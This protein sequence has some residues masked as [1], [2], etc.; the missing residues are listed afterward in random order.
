[1]QYALYHLVVAGCYLQE[2][3][4]GCLASC[5]CCDGIV[6]E[7]NHK[8]IKYIPLWIWIM[9]SGDRRNSK[10]KYFHQWN[11]HLD[12]NCFQNSSYY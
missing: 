6:K 2:F 3:W 9:C 10:A 7:M 1:M 8:W 12:P 5:A 4:V 11:M